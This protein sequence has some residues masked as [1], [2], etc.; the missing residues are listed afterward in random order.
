MVTMDKINT[1][2][3]IALDLTAEI[4]AEDRYDR[5]LGALHRAIPDVAGGVQPWQAVGNGPPVRLGTVEESRKVRGTSQGF[6]EGPV[7]RC[8][9][10]RS[11]G[12][13]SRN[14]GGHDGHPRRRLAAVRGVPAA[15]GSGH[16]QVGCRVVPRA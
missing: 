3:A 16:A 12:T 11:T 6:E 15:L 8:P 10:V 14:L 9:A 5:L 7:Q 2:A 4:S 1:L 13:V